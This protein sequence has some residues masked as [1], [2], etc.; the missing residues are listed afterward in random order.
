MGEEARKFKLGGEFMAEAILADE[1]RAQTCSAE[2]QEILKKY[3]C[4][5]DPFFEMSSVGIKGQVRIL[6]NIRMIRPVG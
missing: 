6:P 5:L 4:I 3:D 1:A 2:I